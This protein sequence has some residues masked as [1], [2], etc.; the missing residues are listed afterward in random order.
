MLHTFHAYPCCQ[1]RQDL[2]DESRFRKK[3]GGLIGDFF[4]NNDISKFRYKNQQKKSLKFIKLA[5][6]IAIN[7]TINRPKNRDK[8]TVRIHKSR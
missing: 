7:H 2:E 8:I 1:N 4:D 3:N 6:F 5:D